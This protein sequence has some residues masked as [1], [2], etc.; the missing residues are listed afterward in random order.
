MIPDVELLRPLVAGWI[1]GAAAGLFITPVLVISMARPGPA[2]RFQGRARLPVLVILFLN[3]LMISLTLVGLLLGAIYYAS[4]GPMF[5]VAVV[6]GITVL[7]VLYVVVRGRIR[8]AEAPVLLISL[9]ILAAAFG[10]LLPFL[11]ER[12]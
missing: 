3:A 11:A 7:A 5:S 10:G 8:T 12:R 2:A 9:V 6:A 1:A 4:G